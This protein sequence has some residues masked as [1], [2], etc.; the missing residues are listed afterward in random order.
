M[1]K[2]KQHS[3]EH[4]ERAETAEYQI[5]TISQEYRKVIENRDAEIR[6]LKTEN[7]KLRDQAKGLVYANTSEPNSPLKELALLQLGGSDIPSSQG[8][9]DSQYESIDIGGSNE[10]VE[11]YHDDFSDIISSQ[12]EINRLQ[13][14]LSKVRLEAQH[15]K[16]MVEDKVF[17]HYQEWVFD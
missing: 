14:E 6:H 9:L 5:S 10:W 15:W 3:D 7:V 1:E 13:M 4:K 16:T 2:L 17:C 12:S 8:P 11:S